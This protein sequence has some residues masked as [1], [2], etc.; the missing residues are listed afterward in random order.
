MEILSISFIYFIPSK[1]LTDIYLTSFDVTLTMP[2]I[3]QLTA[4]VAEWIDRHAK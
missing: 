3:W 2:D 4:N 1:S